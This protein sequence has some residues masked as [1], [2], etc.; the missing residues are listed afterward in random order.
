MPIH[1][2]PPNR[3]YDFHCYECFDSSVCRYTPAHSARRNII[4]FLYSTQTFQILLFCKIFKSRGAFHLQKSAPAP[5]YY[6]TAFDRPALSYYSMENI[7][8][9][10][11]EKGYALRHFSV[12]LFLLRLI[13]GTVFHFPVYYIWLLCCTASR[14]NNCRFFV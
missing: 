4:I 8:K 12:C 14:Y 5:S 13:V 3:G 1:R 10:H 9:P 2:F 7:P 6:F 11:P